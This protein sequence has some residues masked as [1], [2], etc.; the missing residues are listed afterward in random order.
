MS[1]SDKAVISY[2]IEVRH[3]PDSDDWN[4]I[5]SIKDKDMASKRLVRLSKSSYSV[6]LKFRLLKVTTEVIETLDTQSTRGA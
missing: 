4:P 6:S 3:G 1:S 2:K 5:A